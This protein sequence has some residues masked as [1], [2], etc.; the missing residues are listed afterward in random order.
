[1]KAALLAEGAGILEVVGDIDV[2]PPAPGQ[3][4]VTVTHCGI[5]HSDLMVMDTGLGPRPIVLGHEASGIVDAVGE[6]VRSLQPGDHVVLVAIAPCGRCYWCVRGRFTVCREAMSFM[7]G[8]LP[9]GTTALSRGGVPVYRGLGVGGFANQVLTTE[10]GAVRIDDDV[11][12]DL[13]S[14][15]GCAVQTGVGAVLNAAAVEEG[16]TVL[17]LGLGGVGMSVVQGARIAGASRIIG[18][19]PV[20]KRRELALSLG[21][22]D[23][24]DP[25]DVDVVAA[26]AEL[27]GVGADYAFD[28]AGSA[29]LIEQGLLATCAGGTTVSVGVPDMGERLASVPAVLFSTSERRLI[30]SLYG[31]GNPQG[32]IP[33]LVGFWRN[34]LLDL[35]SMV[36]R[37]R[38]LDEV[39]EAV[40]DLRAGLG[41]RTVLS[42]S[43]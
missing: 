20:A 11:P 39:N 28:A 23:V 27:T 31:S 2:P 14:L 40:S 17:V 8:T 37:R 25:T 32:Q 18:S 15:V 5:C 30:G 36:S 42:P 9:D 29:A 4:L 22:T 41:L 13:A 43:S 12:L 35:D 33:R 19:D 38:P 6:G 34:G 16:A 26:C 3:V 1:M 7:V 24:L 21:A 10:T